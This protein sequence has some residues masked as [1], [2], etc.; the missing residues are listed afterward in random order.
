MVTRT[1]VQPTEDAAIDDRAAI[2]LLRQRLPE[3]ATEIDEHLEFTEGEPLFR[4]LMGDLARFYV[5]EATGDQELKRR[6]WMTVDWLTTRGD[7][8]VQNAIAV[9][10]V[11]WFARGESS[12]RTMLVDAKSLMSP[13]VQSIADEFLRAGGY[14]A[15]GRPR[16]G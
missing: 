11:E 6:Y 3:F 13:T 4:L 12:E 15:Q 14:D 10:L 16:T 8:L 1:V 5:R 9:S 7:D 2:E